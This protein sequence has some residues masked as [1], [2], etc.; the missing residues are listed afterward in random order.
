MSRRHINTVVAFSIPA[1]FILSGC[2]GAEK[3]IAAGLQ[4]ELGSER[5]AACI[6]AGQ[7]RDESVL[8]LLV[9]R[10]EDSDADVRLFAIGALKKITGQDLGYRYYASA[11]ERSE[12]VRK[13]RKWL[14]DRREEKKNGG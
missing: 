5:I 8:P 10:L 7:L 12:V 3:D 2:N 13:W 11:S 6:K 9:D 4:A 14:T 1:A